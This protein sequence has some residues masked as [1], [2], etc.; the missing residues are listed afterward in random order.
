MEREE[1]HDS[2]SKYSNGERQEQRNPVFATLF[3]FQLNWYAA[4]AEPKIF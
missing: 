2:N 1:T 4:A 3:L